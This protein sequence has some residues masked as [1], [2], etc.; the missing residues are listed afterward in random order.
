MGGHNPEL[1]MD[2]YTKLF[3]LIREASPSIYI[4]ALTAPE[5]DD[6]ANRCNL[7]YQDVLVQLKNAGLDGLPGGG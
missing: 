4:K 5:I 2:Y 7:S 6:L 3:N 1:G